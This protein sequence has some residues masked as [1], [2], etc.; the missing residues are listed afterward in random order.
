MQTA[1]TNQRPQTEPVQGT[2]DPPGRVCSVS[3]HLHGRSCSVLSSV[4]CICSGECPARLFYPSFPLKEVTVP[5]WLRG[6]SQVNVFTRTCACKIRAYPRSERLAL[7]Y[8]GTISPITF[9]LRV[10]NYAQL[11][12]KS[13]DSAGKRCILRSIIEDC[14]LR[15]LEC[16]FAVSTTP[17]QLTGSHVG[18]F[19]RNEFERHS[20]HAV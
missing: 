18:A 20:G 3:I 17:T 4:A 7:P 8:V 6:R 10:F 13:A 2:S 12:R 5:F 1:L 15:I 11:V 19:I 16:L 14:C 9:P